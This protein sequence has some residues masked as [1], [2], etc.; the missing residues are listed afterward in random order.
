MIKINNKT[1]HFIN[2]IIVGKEEKIINRKPNNTVILRLLYGLI[3]DTSIKILTFDGSFI[4]KNRSIV[5]KLKTDKIH[6]N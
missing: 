2:N 1:K 6:S 3:L 4:N 5:T